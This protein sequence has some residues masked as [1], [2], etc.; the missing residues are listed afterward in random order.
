MA[1]VI[2]MSNWAKHNM[3]TQSFYEEVQGPVLLIISEQSHPTMRSVEERNI[4]KH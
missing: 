3:S 4:V 2:Q 1:L